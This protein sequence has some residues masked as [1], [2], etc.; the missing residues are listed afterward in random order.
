MHHI[1]PMLFYSVKFRH[2]DHSF[3]TIHGV[4]VCHVRPR[5]NKLG[6]RI[7]CIAHVQVM[8]S[9]DLAKQCVQI[10]DVAWGR[11]TNLTCLHAETDMIAIYRRRH[12]N[13]RLLILCFYL[14]LFFF[15]HP[16]PLPL[17]DVSM[18]R[19]SRYHTWS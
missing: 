9:V 14:F 1:A 2:H 17:T 16:M 7:R 4:H 11:H 15:C 8:H 5:S 3:C 6:K 19:Y 12:E 18:L 10:S 13:G